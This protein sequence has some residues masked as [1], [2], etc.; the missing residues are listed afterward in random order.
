MATNQAET[1]KLDIFELS[2]AV[3]VGEPQDITLMG[4]DL[5]IKRRY[6]AAE[7]H[8]ILKLYSEQ[9]E[10]QDVETKATR[11]VA[12]IS[13]SPKAAQKKFVAK[14][15]ELA[16]VEWWRVHSNLLSLAGLADE[17]GHFLPA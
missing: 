10:D 12:L 4:A 15:M 1:N 16:I 14:A 9:A 7:V 8:E 13:S 11:L 3:D 5:T 17:D 6:T 2:C